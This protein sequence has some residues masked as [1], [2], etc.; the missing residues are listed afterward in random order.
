MAT[1]RTG[2]FL[3]RLRGVGGDTD[4]DLHRRFVAARDEQAFT[5]LVKRHGPMGLGVCRH[6]LG[7]HQD[8]EDACQATFL[9]LARKAASI[10]DGG[11]LVSWLHGV[12][13]RLALAARRAAGRR[14]AHEARAEAP[15]QPGPDW[16][17]AWREVQAVLDEE[18]H[19]LPAKLKAPFL[20]CCLEGHGRADAARQ[21]GLKEG[22]VWSRL[23]QARERLQNRLERRGISLPAVLGAA[24]L[25]AGAGDTLPP[26]LA[27]GVTRV[28]LA[29]GTEHIPARVLDL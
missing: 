19:R 15:P 5:A 10:R 28:A 20:L 3:K 26:A 22:T 16:Q 27:A 13:Y 29:T 23:T 8:A 1:D 7:H 25:T 18:I 17:V 24:A 4:R 9:V 14:R 6:V 2:D 12:A 21:L 11:S